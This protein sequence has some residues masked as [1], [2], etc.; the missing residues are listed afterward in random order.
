MRLAAARLRRETSVLFSRKDDWNEQ[1]AGVL[2]GYTPFCYAFS[3]VKL[4][5]FEL[6]FPMTVPDQRY[7]NRHARYLH[8]SKAIVPSEDVLDLC[9]DKMAWSMRLAELGFGECVPASGVRMD[10]PYVLKK[11]VSAYG[12]GTAVIQNAEQ[13]REFESLL[14]A[15]THFV[16]EY[17]EGETEYAA[18]AIVVKGEI[19]FS[20]ACKYYFP[21]GPYVKGR[22]HRAIHRET[23]E[24]APH[25]D[26]FAEI[27]RAINYEGICCIDFKITC[28]GGVKIFEI[29]PRFGA[30]MALFIN[31]AL[32]AYE[33]AVRGY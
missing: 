27:L 1:I 6:L 13:E 5:Q 3:Q 25:L 33:Q 2:T 30:T 4:S 7:L 24:C 31:D 12:D 26:L 29:N 8:G 14:R 18:H 28:D 9:E 10:Y 20:R 11:R 15:D 16:Q 22:A 32:P 23:F 21:T 19:V 17:V